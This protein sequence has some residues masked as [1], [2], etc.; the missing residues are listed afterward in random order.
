MLKLALVSSSCIADISDSFTLHHIN[1]NEQ[2]STVD[3]Q[4]L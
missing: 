3:C 1:G 4:I 2:Y